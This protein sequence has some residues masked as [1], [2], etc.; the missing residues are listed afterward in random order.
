MTNL[1]VLT[2]SELRAFAKAPAAT[3]AQTK[4]KQVDAQLKRL[5]TARQA[6]QPN[7]TPFSTCKQIA[8]VLGYTANGVYQRLKTINVITN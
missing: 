3:P 2:D 6:A 5:Y 1:K 7:E 8:D 4:R